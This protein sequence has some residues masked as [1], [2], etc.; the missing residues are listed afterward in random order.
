MDEATHEAAAE[1]HLEVLRGGDGRVQ[2]RRPWRGERL[3]GVVEVFHD[4]GQPSRRESFVEGRLEGPSEDFDAGGGLRQRAHF[5]AGLL[6]GETTCYDDAGQLQQ[7]IHYRDGLLHGEMTLFAPIEVEG[8]TPRRRG[9]R[10]LATMVYVEGSLQGTLRTYDELERPTFEVP[11]VA[12][13]RQGLASWFHGGVLV[14]QAT[15]VDDLLHGELLDYHANGRV[16]ER[17]PHESDQ[18]HGIAVRYHKN[19]KVKEKL[20]FHHGEQVGD[21][22]Q[23]DRRGQRFDRPRQGAR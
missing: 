15:Y 14:R 10:R 5:K 3:H 2:E 11:Y 19:G 6:D 8:E 7:I 9:V 18:P 20:R 1:E 16:R 22:L 12:G 21:S 13:Q 17:V 4:N 23:Y